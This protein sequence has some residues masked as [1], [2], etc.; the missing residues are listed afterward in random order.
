MNRSTR[1]RFQ[2]FTRRNS[3]ARK[4]AARAV[5]PKAHR[6]SLQI[7][8]LEDRCLMSASMVADIKP[9]TSDGV[10]DQPGVFRHHAVVGETLF[11]L[12]DDGVHGYE[13]WKTD[14]TPSG[15]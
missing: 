5:S 10:L 11:F 7:E 6:R 4:A 2:M 14:G 1:T 9:G 8:Q 12:A 13:L 15:T 3:P